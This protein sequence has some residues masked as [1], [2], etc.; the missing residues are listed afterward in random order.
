MTENGGTDAVGSTHSAGRTVPAAS[1]FEAGLTGVVT[2]LSGVVGCLCCYY[3][4][5]QSTSTWVGMFSTAQINTTFYPALLANL[6]ISIKARSWVDRLAAR[7]RQRGRR[8][9][10]RRESL[11]PIWPYSAMFALLAY[12][13]IFGP[14]SG[15]ALTSPI[16]PA[17]DRTAAMKVLLYTDGILAT[18]LILAGTVIAM[19][20]MD[21]GG[22]GS[23]LVRAI[24]WIASTGTRGVCFFRLH[25]ASFYLQ[26]AGYVPMSVV[27]YVGNRG[28]LFG[29]GYLLGGLAMLSALLASRGYLPEGRESKASDSEPEKP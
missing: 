15:D 17:M 2:A 29:I 23:H 8:T 19:D 25:D 20:E 7:A 9:D 27:L 6:A 5:S 4:L 24:D 26:P 10:P 12:W 3:A 14:W 13:A 11:L 1:R 16:F 22:P 18:I 28:V 21:F